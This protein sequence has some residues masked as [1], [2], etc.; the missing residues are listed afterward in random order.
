MSIR[1]WILIYSLLLFVPQAA[2]SLSFRFNLS[3]PAVVD[4][5][6][7][8]ELTC[9]GDAFQIPMLGSPPRT[10]STGRVSYRWPVPLWNRDTGELASFAI[11]FTFRMYAT[12]AS[13]VGKDWAGIA[14]DGMAF[15]LGHYPSRIPDDSWGSNLGLLSRDNNVAAAGDARIVAVEFDTFGNTNTTDT[16]D[17]PHMGIDV[18]SIISVAYTN[19][20][21]GLSGGGVLLSAKITY[22]NATKLLAANLTMDGGVTWYKVSA[23]IDLRSS[24]PE[25]VA[26]GFSAAT[27]LGVQVNEILSWTFDSTSPSVSRR[28]RGGRVLLL[29]AVLVPVLFATAAIALCCALLGFRPWRRHTRSP[30]WYW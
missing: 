27:G 19:V 23:A 10:F 6:R 5:C 30:R 4:P 24:L 3:D 7:G 26:V 29:V 1:I 20:G 25:E 14:A 13:T 9:D 18:N 15:F 28:R 8:S 12:N 21:S 2:S 16:T 17:R 22:D 11:T